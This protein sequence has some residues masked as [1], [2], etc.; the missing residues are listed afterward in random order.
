[1]S[2]LLSNEINNT[3]K[4]GVFVSECYRMGIEI[5][6]P[7][8]NKSQKRFAPEKMPN[9]ESSIRYGLAAIKNVG[10]AAM[11][12]LI[13]NRDQDGKFES[14][15]DMANRLDGKVIN[16]RILEN[17]IKAGALD[18]TGESR[19]G[20]TLRLEQVLSAA[21][22]IQKDRASGQGALF[23]VEEVSS[24][25]SMTESHIEQI[26]EWPKEDRLVHEKELLGFYVTG[27]P[28]DKFRGVIDGEAYTSFGMISELDASDKRKKYKFGGMISHV[29][30]KVTR[31][32]K[33]FGVLHLE[34]FTGDTEVVL[35]S[36]TYNP[37]K[38][39]GILEPGKVIR[40]K[41][42]IQ[43]D[44]R[45]EEIRLAFCSEVTE[46]KAKSKKLKGLELSLSVL[47]HNS[48][49]LAKIKEILK[50]HPGKT[51]VYLRFS[52]SKGRNALISAGTSYQVKNS[53][54]LNA[55]LSKW[56]DIS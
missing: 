26:A 41:S 36:E 47:R 25:P 27:H 34:D 30:H 2:A 18:W 44:D 28:L 14:L 9:G 1:M 33:P 22:A 54:Q 31:A 20:M 45:T 6:P 55:E 16:R 38:E 29:E 32:G 17:L 39:A 50:K 37:A 13:Q 40:F 51:E 48:G 15:D 19:A 7:D 3:D 12:M 52:G 5:L 35:W 4:I 21:N 10:E 11:E 56:I 42:G 8:M 49:D 24:A 43:V 46:V 53:P 23:G